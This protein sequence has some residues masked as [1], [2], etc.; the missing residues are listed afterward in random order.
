MTPN[1]VVANQQLIRELQRIPTTRFTHN[2][3]A[4]DGMVFL[5]HG[6][7]RVLVNF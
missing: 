5:Q 6:Y 1:C 2:T 4:T 7:F 3:H